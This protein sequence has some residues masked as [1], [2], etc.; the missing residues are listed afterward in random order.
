MVTLFE[1]HDFILKMN[2]MRH[3]AKLIRC[4]QDEIDKQRD[5]IRSIF[6]GMEWAGIHELLNQD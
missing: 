5:Y 3:V 6:T 2:T 1:Q 4:F